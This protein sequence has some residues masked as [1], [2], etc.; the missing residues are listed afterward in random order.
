MV[1]WPPWTEIDKS[2]EV[3]EVP[4]YLIEMFLTVWGEVARYDC[5]RLRNLPWV[6]DVIY[7]IGGNTGTFTLFSRLLFPHA[8]IVTI[9]PDPNNLKM[10]RRVCD[11]ILGVTLKQAALALA[12]PVL[13]RSR[14]AGGGNQVY[15]SPGAIGYPAGGDYEPSSVPPMSLSEILAL[16]PPGKSV[17]KVDCEG[18]E[19]CI[20]GDP[21]SMAALATADFIAM[22]LHWYGEASA[23]E[24]VREV[25]AQGIESLKVTHDVE[26]EG[27]EL[28]AMKR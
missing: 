8:A 24:Q 17:L 11:V 6:P 7:D 14:Q 26:L 12:P 19:N 4:Q 20:F 28:W 1:A 2:L 23:V 22:E 13:N 21:T 5:Y 18:G 27:N 10:L 25:T 15:I 9:E 16:G 3:N